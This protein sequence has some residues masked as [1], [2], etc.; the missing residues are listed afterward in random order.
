M[1]VDFKT[2]EALSWV[3]ALGSFH[4]AAD[5]LR[6]TQPA[7]SQRVARLEDALGRRLFER[8]PRRVV[9]TAAG[10]EALVFAE[11]LLA[12]RAEM[13]ARLADP[14]RL[15]GVLRLGVAETIVHTWLSRFV[16]AMSQAL[17]RVAL[18]IEVDASPVL[19]ER[20]LAQQIDLAFLIG[21]LSVPEVRARPDFDRI[22]TRAGGVCFL[23]LLP[24]DAEARADPSAA[25]NAA[26]RKAEETST[27]KMG[28]I[29]AGMPGLPGGMKFP[30]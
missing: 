6:T 13:V 4:L 23:A 27:E 8:H 17:P 30:F 9:P 28:K 11:R 29:T 25:F 20:L 7:I 2:L 19:R 1:S 5:K 10:R 22:C 14:E 16:E 3:A 21:P 26:V 18:E 12:T 24:G 15:V